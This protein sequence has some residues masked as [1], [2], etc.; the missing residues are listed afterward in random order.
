LEELDDW[1]QAHASTRVR[2]SKTQLRVGLG[3]F[4]IYSKE[5]K[6]LSRQ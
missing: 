4:S 6:S 1:L 3:V 5:R 2:G